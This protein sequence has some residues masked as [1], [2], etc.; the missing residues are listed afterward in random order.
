M[1]SLRSLTLKMSHMCCSRGKSMRRFSS[2]VTS[3]DARL[4][5]NTQIVSKAC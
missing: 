2:N 5:E 1:I 3:D 4:N